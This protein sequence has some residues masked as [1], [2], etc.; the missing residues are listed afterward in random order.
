MT[1]E[2]FSCANSIL[3][4]T[5]NDASCHTPPALIEIYASIDL[6]SKTSV[7]TKINHYKVNT[8]TNSQ[9]DFHR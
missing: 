4:T 9:Y 2:P 8:V 6:L 7:D 5:A 3:V 1:L